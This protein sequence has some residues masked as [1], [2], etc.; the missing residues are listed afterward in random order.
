MDEMNLE[1]IDL[2]D[3][4]RQRVQARLASAPIVFSGPIAGELLNRG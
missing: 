2:G 1:P 3:E 4:L